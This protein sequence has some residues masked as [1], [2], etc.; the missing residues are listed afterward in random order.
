MNKL[1]P[2]NLFTQS[3]SAMLVA[4]RIC[5]STPLSLVFLLLET[6][7][8]AEPH[9]P[10][11]FPQY[12][13]LPIQPAARSAVPRSEQMTGL[14][15]QVFVMAFDNRPNTKRAGWNHLEKQAAAARTKW[16]RTDVPLQNAAAYLH[17]AGSLLPGQ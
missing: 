1:L 7:R 4:Y 12:L 3:P 2:P 10:S 16:L 14:I 13:Q 8:G 15:S 5:E 6:H 17:P 11:P 9:A